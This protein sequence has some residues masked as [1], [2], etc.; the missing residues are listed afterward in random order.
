LKYKGKKDTLW[1]RL[2]AKKGVPVK[3]AWDWQ[4]KEMT[5][6]AKVEDEAPEKLD[7]EEL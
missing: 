6:K 5:D 7:G 3:H 2:E 4:M 1:C